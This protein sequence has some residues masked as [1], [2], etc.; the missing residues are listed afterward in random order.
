M[1][2]A[3][4]RSTRDRPL[5]VDARAPLVSQVEVAF[6]KHRYDQGALVECLKRRWKERP[7]VIGL[8]ERLH[9]S[10]QVEERFLALPLEDYDRMGNDFGASNDAFIR[11][12]TEL[13][14]QAVTGAIARA[15]LSLVDLDAIFFTTVTGVAAPSIDARL[16]NVLGLRRDIRRTPMFGLGCLGGAAGLAR[17][18][19]YLRGHPEHV[20]VLVSVE[21]CSL[22]LQEDVSIANLVASGLFGDGAAA[23]VLIGNDAPARS[24]RANGPSSAGPASIRG[25]TRARVVDTKSAFF[26]NTERVMGWDIGSSGF[27]VVLSADVPKIVTQYLPAEVDGFLGHHGLERNDV[28]HWICHPGGPK[29]I[30]A[31]E[32]SLELPEAALAI[33]RE[34][35]ASVGNLSSGSVLHV[36]GKTQP[37]ALPGDV[38]LLMAM[39]PG[40]CAELVLLSW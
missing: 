20:A 17:T 24:S 25:R 2:Q 23:V 31:I 33:T 32:E 30:A 5:H 18:S 10:V 12:G 36:L 1:S 22:T 38:G 35:L 8:L 34:S 3:R 27:K 13:A 21:L 19:D 40:F 6:P 7:K 29:V 16:V 14:A 4:I 26:P 15:G 11:V 9:A 28:C 37:R 39:G